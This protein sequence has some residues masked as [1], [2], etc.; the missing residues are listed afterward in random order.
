MG[1]QTAMEA[2]V[3][4]EAI[5]QPGAVALGA[6]PAPRPLPALLDALGWPPV[7]LARRLRISLNT[8]QAWAKGQRSAPP[9]V[10][11]WL[12]HL[13]IVMESCPAVPPGWQ[14]V[15]RGRRKGAADGA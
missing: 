5:D 1:N 13:A 8:A 11:A 14:G 4:L 9:E 3:P 6:E 7:T 2:D 10:L 12:S 15:A